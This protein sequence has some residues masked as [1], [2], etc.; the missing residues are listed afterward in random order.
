MLID[1]TTP[2]PEQAPAP[3]PE[4]Q[5]LYQH[6]LDASQKAQELQQ[7]SNGLRVFDPANRY[8]HVLEKNNEK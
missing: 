2:D 3:A 6:V 4:A 5:N 7:K 1:E 8:S